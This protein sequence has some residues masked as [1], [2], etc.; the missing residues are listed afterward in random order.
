MVRAA[1]VDDE[2]GLVDLTSWGSEGSWPVEHTYERETNDRGRK[3]ID[4]AT[5]DKTYDYK[6]A[7]DAWQEDILK[8][9]V[10]EPHE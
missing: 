10:A 8:P 6:E 7:M 3:I 1:L 4:E 5:S 2:T 9:Q